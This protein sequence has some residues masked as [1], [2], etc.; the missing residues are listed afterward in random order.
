MHP[1]V[2][3]SM[4]DC[5]SQKR[6]AH[7]QVA[8]W[9]ALGRA[10]LHSS[11]WCWCP[12]V[13]ATMASNETTAFNN[14]IV[15][16]DRKKSE[17]VHLSNPSSPNSASITIIF[18]LSNPIFYIICEVNDFIMSFISHNWFSQQKTDWNS[19]WSESGEKWMIN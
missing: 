19:F 11:L 10:W 2:P 7:G 5:H 15:H 8:P 12:G 4:S 18:V 14:F 17:S 1:P 13:D 6:K 16:T 9:C 3:G